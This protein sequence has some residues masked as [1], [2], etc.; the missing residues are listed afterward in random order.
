MPHSKTPK[1]LREWFSIKSLKWY[2]VDLTDWHNPKVLRK[3][4]DDK[5]Q[6]K[7]FINRNLKGDWQPVYGKEALKM[8]LTHYKNRI[9][10]KPKY[11]Y[12][13]DCKTQKQ[14]HLF[15]IMYRRKYRE[16]IQ[17]MRITEEVILDILED[18]PVK[19]VKRMK[20]FKKYHWAYSQPVEGF[21][22]FTKRYKYPRDVVQ[23]SRI[24]KTLEK[25]HYDVAEF[26]IAKIATKIYKLYQN[27]INKHIGDGDN[28]K[29]NLKK[30]EKE[31]RA[32]GFIPAEEYPWEE[33]YHLVKT[34]HLKP[35]LI[36]PE[37][38]YHTGDEMEIYQHRTY[39]LQGLVGIPGYCR[40]KIAN[41]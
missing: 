30:L 34:I 4:F 33:R 21:K 9:V 7:E 25:Y 36:Y 28:P 35:N 1:L 20:S 5:K 26:P 22:Y 41:L 31:Y 37:P 29:L 40:A 23:L 2:V 32:R 16:R 15:R 11:D 18:A 19:F 13:K 39:D 8:D 12:P 38:C 3:H 24:V 27:R 17:S 6:A 10:R 14:R